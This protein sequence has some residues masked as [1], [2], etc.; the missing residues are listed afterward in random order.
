MP[1]TDPKQTNKLTDRSQLTDGTRDAHFE[2]AACYSCSKWG[3]KT[4]GSNP[5]KS[6]LVK[7][8]EV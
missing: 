7:I 3:S 1:K 2:G 4:T 8:D 5:L 6:A